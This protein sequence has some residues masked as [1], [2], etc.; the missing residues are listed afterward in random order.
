[1]DGGGACPDAQEEDE[2][3]GKRNR[4]ASGNS[5]FTAALRA[6]TGSSPTHTKSQKSSSGG[7]LQAE[8]GAGAGPEV[9]V[10]VEVEDWRMRTVGAV[11]AA[12]QVPL[13]LGGKGG[14]C[15]TT[16]ADDVQEEVG[17]GRPCAHFNSGTEGVVPE[18]EWEGSRARSAAASSLRASASRE[19]M[20]RR[21]EHT[22]TTDRSSV[23]SC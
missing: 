23:N 18:R 9:G 16:Y 1:M 3:E 5:F 4:M 17:W 8:A 22:S 12:R 15:R 2:G 14:A 20:R 6:T 7:S 21:G 19:M 13:L 11:E 10:E